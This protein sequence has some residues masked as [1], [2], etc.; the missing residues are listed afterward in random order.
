MSERRAINPIMSPG[1]IAEEVF[2]Q[3]LKHNQS[4]ATRIPA[5]AANI[6]TNIREICPM[7]L[8]STGVVMVGH[9]RSLLE[10]RSHSENNEAWFI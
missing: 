8:F 4:V 1:I 7:R 2:S 3:E 9:Y 5:S 6:P 10:T